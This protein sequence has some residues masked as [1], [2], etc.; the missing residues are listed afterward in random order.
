M[1]LGSDS[2][3]DRHTHATCHISHSPFLL[4]WIPWATCALA[5]LLKELGA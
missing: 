5:A 1:M 2:L 4:P 3:P